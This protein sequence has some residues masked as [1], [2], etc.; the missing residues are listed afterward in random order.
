MVCEVE[1]KGLVMETQKI[2]EVVAY[3]DGPMGGLW[4][5]TEDGSM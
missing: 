4:I 3:E 5:A 2:H 1:D